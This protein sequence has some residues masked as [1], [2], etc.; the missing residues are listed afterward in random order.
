MVL[1]PPASANRSIA[2]SVSRRT[3]A[4]P[5]SRPAPQS[6]APAAARPPAAPPAGACSRGGPTFPRRRTGRPG[7][8]SNGG[9]R[10]GTGRPAPCP[11]PSTACL[12]VSSDS[13]LN[14]EKLATRRANIDLEGTSA[15]GCR[16]QALDVAGVNNVECTHEGAVK[17]KVQAA[18]WCTPLLQHHTH[19]H[20]G[21]SLK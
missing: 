7:R 14:I 13:Q 11:G 20:F 6:Q 4:L 8:S 21:C 5:G 2:M 19:I 18:C 17:E 15:A 3:A 1:G 12:K 10:R 16:H 9:E